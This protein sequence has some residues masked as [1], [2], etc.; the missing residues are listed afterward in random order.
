MSHNP[1]IDLDIE[2]DNDLYPPATPAHFYTALHD[3][4]RLHEP[5]SS[6]DTDYLSPYQD[7]EMESPRAEPA[8]G[9]ESRADPESTVACSICME[10]QNNK[11]LV[12]LP[13]RHE[14]CRECLKTLFEKAIKEE[15]LFPPRCCRVIPIKVV[16]MFLNP[17]ILKEYARKRAELTTKDRTYCH[18]RDCKKFICPS[19]V[20]DE[21]AICPDCGSTT[22]TNC[23][24]KAHR[25]SCPSQPG[26]KELLE[27][28]KEEGWKQ[29][30][31]CLRMIERIDG[32]PFMRCRCGAGFCYKCGQA[33]TELNPECGCARAHFEDERFGMP[34]PYAG[35]AFGYYLLRDFMPF[36]NLPAGRY[37]MPDLDHAR[38]AQDMEEMLRR[39]GAPHMPH[40]RR[41][42][43]I[44]D[45]VFGG[46]TDAEIQWERNHARA[47]AAQRRRGRY[48]QARRENR[49]ENENENE[50]R[51]ANANAN[52]S[53]AAV[54]LNPTT[55][56]FI[57][58]RNMAN[59]NVGS[60]PH[61]HLQQTPRSQRLPVGGPRLRYSLETPR[62]RGGPNP[63]IPGDGSRVP[64]SQSAQ[65]RRSHPE[66][67]ESRSGG[68]ASEPSQAPFVIDGSSNRPAA[69]PVMSRRNADFPGVRNGVTL[70]LPDL[71]HT[72]R[73]VIK[74]DEERVRSSTSVP[75]RRGGD[76][77]PIG[78]IGTPTTRSQDSRDPGDKRRPAPQLEE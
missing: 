28:A 33:M 51:N 22:C 43:N 70:H 63:F 42:Q 72:I 47:I 25:N 8:A 31:S 18:N 16:R 35:D 37:V 77:D 10:H 38:Q 57:P 78:A 21:L 50:N 13:C 23:K 40:R 11:D 2:R 5:A 62:P 30:W 55:A 4:G 17:E 9:T 59:N 12:V 46:R 27:T 19:Y 71:N 48:P 41:P 61:V 26:L 68:D 7:E 58:R 36:P 24:N 73:N 29:C 49:N 69:S 60:T 75:E 67:Q 15:S 1:N 6:S 64:P 54:E 34:G 76:R 3:L 45:G 39:G 32:C 74:T 53:G 14:Y 20:D 65:T 44:R 66:S 56:P 52:A